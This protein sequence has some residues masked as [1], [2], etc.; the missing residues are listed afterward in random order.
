MER[1]LTL[2]FTDGTKL[3]F[4]FDVQAPNAMARK[5]KLED[6]MRSQHLVIEGE[7]SVFLFPVANIK[8][9]TFTSLLVDPRELAAT[10]PRQA[11]LQAR[12]HS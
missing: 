5:L 2:F 1:V 3:S 6:F 11:I 7:G 10:L 8:Y 4:D 9:M 12:M